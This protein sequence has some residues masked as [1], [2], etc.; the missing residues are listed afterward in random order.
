[1]RLKI[2]EAVINIDQSNSTMENVFTEINSILARKQQVIDH[3]EVDGV[4]LYDDFGTFFEEHWSEIKEVVVVTQ[5]I[6]ELVQSSLNTARE[7]L[8]RALPLMENIVNDLYCGPNE[9]VWKEF[10]QML[11][12]F[13]WLMETSKLFADHY[14]TVPYF[15]QFSLVLQPKI[16]ELAEAMENSDCTLMA[17]LLSYEILP[18]LKRLDGAIAKLLGGDG[19]GSYAN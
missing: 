17:D 4:E 15:Q 6:F 14:T 8:E 10:L 2:N 11:D 18:E 12:G 7:Y 16:G 9:Q 19:D 1:M 13:Q 3:I 5:G